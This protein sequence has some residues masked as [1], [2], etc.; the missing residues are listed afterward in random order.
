MRY[1]AV[2]QIRD[3]V[4]MRGRIDS[5]DRRCYVFF[6]PALID[7]PLIFV[8]VALTREIPGAIAPI[9]EVKREPLDPERATAAVFYS[10]SN[11]Q[12]G[13]AGVTFG[14]F[15][16]TQVLAEICRDMPRLS[17]FVTLS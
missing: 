10:I 13:L 15:L 17:T 11:C 2:D 12:R 3:W 1:E 6:H 14:S 16:I 9:L 8:E 4:D 5:Q 7:E